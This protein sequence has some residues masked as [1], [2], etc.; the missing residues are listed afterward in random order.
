V[1]RIWE[2]YTDITNQVKRAL[3]DVVRSNADVLCV[4]GEVPFADRALAE[5]VFAKMNSVV[6]FGAS[7]DAYEVMWAALARPDCAINQLSVDGWQPDISFATIQRVNPRV[8][9][10]S[11]AHTKDQYNLKCY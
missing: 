7:K 3:K 9:T 4:V 11:I 8:R 2:N 10:I 6:L 5:R 1:E